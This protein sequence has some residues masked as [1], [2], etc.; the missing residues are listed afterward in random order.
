[1]HFQRG[2]IPTI[3]VDQAHTRLDSYLWLIYAGEQARRRQLW[4]VFVQLAPTTHDSCNR[5]SVRPASRRTWSAIHQH[6]EC[7]GVGG[8]PGRGKADRAF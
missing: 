2:Q 5:L 7:I 4:Q 8:F 3:V 1:M 6:W